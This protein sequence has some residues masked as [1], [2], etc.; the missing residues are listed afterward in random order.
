MSQQSRV[1]RA[2]GSR[3]RKHCECRRCHRARW[4]LRLRRSLRRDRPTDGSR[5][6]PLSPSSVAQP[7][8]LLPLSGGYK[9]RRCF[10]RPPLSLGASW[11]R[12]RRSRGIRRASFSP[13]GKG[14][15]EGSEREQKFPLDGAITRSKEEG[16][17]E[18]RRTRDAD[19]P[20]PKRDRETEERR[21][22]IYKFIAEGGREVHSPTHRKSRFPKLS[23]SSGGHRGG[24]RG[25]NYSLVAHRIR[26]PTLGN[27]DNERG[28]KSLRNRQVG[29]YRPYPL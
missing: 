9:S 22:R 17:K 12:G 26:L 11:I 14:E 24:E 23:N 27:K 7:L 10:R 21:R 1:P 29:R 6:R 20:T 15:S 8:V 3:A 2:N 18:G 19:G 4:G 16:G 25:T 13:T 5:G 28:E